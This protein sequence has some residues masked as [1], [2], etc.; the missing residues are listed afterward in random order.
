MMQK[1]LK[2]FRIDKGINAMFVDTCSDL[3]INQSD[4]IELLII[5]WLQLR[6]KTD[7]R[8]AKIY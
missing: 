5:R 1:K 3:N 4:V 6:K 8:N 2:A 7:K